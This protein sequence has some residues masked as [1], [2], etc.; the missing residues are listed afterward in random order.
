MGMEA[1]RSHHRSA[2]LPRPHFWH[3]KLANVYARICLAGQHSVA[4]FVHANP[5]W[6]YGGTIRVGANAGRSDHHA[7][8]ASRRVL[9]F[10]LQPTM[11]AG[12]W[13]GHAF[14]FLVSHDG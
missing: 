4:A 14:L 9:A 11:V 1:K 12:F 13:V 7:P 10:A 6:L 2:S 8:V 5:P 3:L